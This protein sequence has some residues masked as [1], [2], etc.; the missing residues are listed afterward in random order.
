MPSISEVQLTEWSDGMNGVKEGR[1]GRKKWQ[2][3][4]KFLEWA[5]EWTKRYH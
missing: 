3:I 2:L 5:I 1:W 4:T